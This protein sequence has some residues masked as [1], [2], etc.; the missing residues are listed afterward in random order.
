MEV[1]CFP[2]SKNLTDLGVAQSDEPARMCF[3][4][5]D[6]SHLREIMD[7][8]GEIADNECI[9]YFKNGDS[10]VIDISYDVA[11]EKIFAEAHFLKVEIEEEP[12]SEILPDDLDDQPF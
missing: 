8:N 12:V 3:N 1:N 2:I 10:S 5:C 11:K 6:V 4:P 9:V 7:D